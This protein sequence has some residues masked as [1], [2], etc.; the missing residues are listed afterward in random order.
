M[1]SDDWFRNSEWDSAIEAK[2]LEKLRRARDKS[3]YLRIQ[4]SYLAKK[5]PK[6][7]LDLLNKY[8]ALGDDFDL[9][10]ALVNQ[11]T[12]YVALDRTQDGVQSLRKALIR[13]REF[14]NLKTE[15][16]SEFALLVAT[17]N[18]QSYFQEALQVLEDH[19]SQVMFPVDKFKWYAAYALI[20][21]AQGD[22][23]A[24]K[25]QAIR[26][27]DAAKVSHSGFRYHSKVGLVESKYETLRDVL[28]ELSNART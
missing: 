7:A 17:Q 1:A 3:Q 16:W 27:L 10:Q 6:A 22:R 15:A 21:A 19:Q 14:P 4:A 2:F 18:L 20:M 23:V 28:S 25:A 13:E 11:A 8:F 5:H 12:A 26:A 9:A 24:A